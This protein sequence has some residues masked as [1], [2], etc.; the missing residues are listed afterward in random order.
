M[1]DFPNFTRWWTSNKG[2]INNPSYGLT[3]M[4]SHQF[5]DT[6]QATRILIKPPYMDFLFATI[7]LFPYRG[8]W[9]P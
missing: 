6:W 7:P 2:D 3:S 9:E 5:T 1:Q 4:R 8:F